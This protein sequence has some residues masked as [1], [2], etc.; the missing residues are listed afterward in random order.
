MSGGI[1]TRTAVKDPVGGLV[2]G[3]SLEYS[4]EGPGKA[5]PRKFYQFWEALGTRYAVPN[6]DLQS[7]LHAIIER[8]FYVKKDGVFQRPPMFKANKCRVRHFLKGVANKAGM[9]FPCSP[10]EFCERYV[11]NKR[12]LYTNA[13][14][15]L[16]KEGLTYMDSVIRCF[17][18]AEYIKPG[19]VPRLIQPRQPRYNACLGCFLSPN[20][21]KIFAAIDTYM[22]VDLGMPQERTIAKGMNMN[23][24]GE[25]IS[26]M[27]NSYDDPVAIGLDAARFD[28]HINETLLELEHSLYLDLFGDVEGPIGD[29]KLSTMLKWQRRN[30]CVWGDRENRVMYKT[31]GCRMSGD[32]NTSLGN[33]I[34]MTMLWATF[35]R[36]TSL[37]FSL[38]NDGDD[39]CVVCSRRTAKKIVKQVEAFFLEF[40]ITMVVEGVF[41]TMEEITFC[42]AKPVY[43]GSSWYLC[44]NPHKRVFSDINA[45]K[46]LSS[47][48]TMNALLGAVAACGLACNGNTPILN[49]LYKKMGTGVKLYIPDRRHHL[50]KFR[51]ELLDG[52]Q[53]KFV[54]PTMEHRISFSLAFGI[55]PGNQLL[56]EEFLRGLPTI[57]HCLIRPTGIKPS[58]LEMFDPVFKE[59]DDYEGSESCV[60][61]ATFPPNLTS[62]IE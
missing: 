37:R 2:K 11:G 16:M 4:M 60:L 57:H 36:E 13:C 19:G 14:S 22:H 49:E 30:R 17:T 32:M 54:E 35:K 55:S 41:D 31:K 20:E 47:A 34:I 29:V 38:L 3:E 39:S 1:S 45:I 50:Y 53:P 51:Q 26:D 5:K 27:W 23:A 40:G 18:K 46:D 24:R 21:H 52:M 9:L 10:E 28:Q 42:Q 62:R 61:P 43:N 58:V 8:V 7:V 25:A 6:N 48:K 33:I 15:S 12:R 44:P 59:S 56:L